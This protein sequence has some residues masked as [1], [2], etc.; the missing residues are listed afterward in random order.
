MKLVELQKKIEEVFKDEYQGMAYTLK[1]LSV[2]IADKDIIIEE[3]NL[4]TI[5]EIIAEIA[6]KLNQ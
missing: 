2:G 1:N 6:E 3:Y 4:K 5:E